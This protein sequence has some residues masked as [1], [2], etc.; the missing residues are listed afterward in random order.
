MRKLI[1]YQRFKE[2]S[3]LLEQREILQY[4]VF[5][6]PPE[7]QHDTVALA[8]E[9]V[10]TTLFELV[11]ALK[12]VIA[13]LPEER[14]HEVMREE[15]SITTRIYQVIERLKGRPRVEFEELFTDVQNKG[16]VIITF[17]SVLELM[18]RRLVK[19]QQAMQG[20]IIHIFPTGNFDDLGEVNFED[21]GGTAAAPAEEEA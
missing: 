2:A 16:L 14:V 8:D 20:T 10:D 19:V 4:D 3:Q 7:P 21:Y 18:K 1:E 17:L 13:R 11:S 5:G 12:H 15:I 6:H 9:R